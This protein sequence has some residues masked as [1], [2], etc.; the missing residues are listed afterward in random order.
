L[1]EGRL[2]FMIKLLE[3]LSYITDGQRTLSSTKSESLIR[4]RKSVGE[5]EANK[6]IK[7]YPTFKIQCRHIFEV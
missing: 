5:T 4:L 7:L 6:D 2:K 1:F 3:S